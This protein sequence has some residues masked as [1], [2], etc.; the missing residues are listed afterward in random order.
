M[1]KIV[2]LVGN[3]GSG[4]T[5]YTHKLVKEGYVAI[6]RD[7]LRYMIGNGKY[8][9]N[10][11]V[12]PAVFKSEHDI[13]KNFMRLGVDIVIDEVG[14]QHYLRKRYTAL[15]KKYGY[16][17]IC[18]VLP[19]LSMK[20]CVDRRMQDPHGQPD[21]ALWEAVWKKF[22]KQRTVPCLDEGFDKIVYIKKEKHEL[23][24]NKM[25]KT[26]HNIRGIK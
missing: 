10:P 17:A 18:M 11:E 26:I 25:M 6:S 8:T 19:R 5:T 13:I 20:E 15:A 1:L 16:K 22:E 2:I 21:R 23:G 7:A 24:F 9:F 14:V 3:I 12:E 4:K